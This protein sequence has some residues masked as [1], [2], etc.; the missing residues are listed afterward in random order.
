MMSGRLDE[1]AYL[2]TWTPSSFPSTA[3]IHLA[4]LVQHRPRQCIGVENV[5]LA[6]YNRIRTRS[7]SAAVILPTMSKPFV[8]YLELTQQN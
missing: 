6:L 2:C 1:L 7:P 3:S 5:V 4:H 8:G